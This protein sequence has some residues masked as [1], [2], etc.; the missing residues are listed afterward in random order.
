MIKF[1]RA[2]KKTKTEILDK[3]NT[4]QQLLTECWDVYNVIKREIKQ[5]IEICKAF[6]EW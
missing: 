3:L 6:A 1:A 5:V 4:L 2:V